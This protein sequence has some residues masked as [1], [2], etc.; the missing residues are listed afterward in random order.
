MNTLRPLIQEILHLNHQEFTKVEPI[1]REAMNTGVQDLDYLERISEPLENI[2][3]AS[4]IG[5]ELYDEFLDYIA[6][7]NPQKAKEYRDFYDDLSGVYDDLVAEAANFAKEFHKG[8]VDKAGVDYFEGHLTTVGGAGQ[9]WKEK[10]VGFLHDVAE[11]TAH[12]VDE[13][14]KI[15]KDKS[16][17]IL[18]DEDAEEI[19]KALYLLNANTASSREE[20]IERIKESFIATKVKLNDLSHNMDISRLPNPTEKEMERIKRYRREYRQAL[21]YLGNVAW[22]WDESEI[23]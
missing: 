23:E 11:D 4:G 5:Q 21:G 22:E 3:L 18:K 13:I 6:S 1:V 16:N 14:V 8:Q 10:I 9:D 15:L 17:G 19:S 7:F 12:S 20:Y 2:L